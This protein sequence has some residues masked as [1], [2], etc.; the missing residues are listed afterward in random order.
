M[1]VI[2]PT[3]NKGG[4]GKTKV[5]ILL[6]EYF[7]IVRKKRVLALDLDPQCNFSQR[8]LRMEI[9]PSSPQ[10]RVPP[11][12]PDY[13]P[14]D[15]DCEN[16]DGRSSIADIFFEPGIIP[17][18]THIENLDI[19]P[20]HADKLLEAEAVRRN[21]MVERV[22][23]QMKLFMEDPEIHKTYDIM[24]IDTAPSKGPLT[25]SAIR[26]ATHILIPSVMEEQ[27]IQGVYGMLQLWMQES[28][29]RDT[30]NP[31]NLLGILPNMF[32]ATNLHQDMLRSL[33]DN[34]SIAKYVMPVKLGQRTVF[35]EVDAEGAIPK[36]IF[37]LPNSNPAKQ[38][39]LSVCD[40]IAERIN[41]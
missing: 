27:P 21:E 8:F 1:I 33:Q 17:Y 5:S 9:D 37:D 15:P 23:N 19:A 16:W 7:S 35:A 18:P 3:N 20:G 41:I 4:V 26:A 14:V 40:Y 32:R 2:A 22:Y 24:V 29:R 38:E 11:I 25:I 28:L 13:D 31:L 34:P 36:T 12:H 6:S 39:A 10:G 30:K